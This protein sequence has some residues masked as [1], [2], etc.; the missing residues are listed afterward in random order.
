MCL[1]VHRPL[2][3]VKTLGCL[4]L[5]LFGIVRFMATDAFQLLKFSLALLD[6]ADLFE[7]GGY[8]A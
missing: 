1:D 6:A 2:S 4:A 5:C 7:T 8:L 3:W